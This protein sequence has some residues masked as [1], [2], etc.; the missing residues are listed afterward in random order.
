MVGGYDLVLTF[1]YVNI[2]CSSTMQI[3][4]SAAGARVIDSRNVCHSGPL[5]ILYVGGRLSDPF[6]FLS[7]YIDELSGSSLTPFIVRIQRHQPQSHAVL[8]SCSLAIS[9]V[10]F[11]VSDEQVWLSGGRQAFT[12]IRRYIDMP[13]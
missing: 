5:Q 6:S 10:Y 2:L 11:K 9:C 1:F 7:P 3:L 12:D 8:I 4:L 13:R